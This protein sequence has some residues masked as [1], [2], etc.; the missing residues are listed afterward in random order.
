MSKYKVGDELK[1]REWD[2]MVDEFGI[3]SWGTIRCK[4]SF[5][6]EMKYLCGSDFTVLKIIGDDYF[7]V[8]KIE[9]TRPD[10][11]YW[12]ISKDMLEPRTEEDLYVASDDELINLLNI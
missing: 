1:I 6:E 11:D 9:R 12:H 7:S 3:T 10:V 5:N 8:E 2:D 4:N